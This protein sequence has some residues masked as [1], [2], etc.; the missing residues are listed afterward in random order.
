MQLKIEKHDDIIVEWI[1]YDHSIMLK[2]IGKDG[3]ATAIWK[4]GSLKYN[5]EVMKF[6]ILKMLLYFLLQQLLYYLTGLKH[7]S[8]KDGQGEIPKIYGIFHDPYTKEFF[9]VLDC[10][11]EICEVQLKIEEYKNIIVEW[12]PYDQ[13]NI[14]KEISFSKAYL[15][16][17]K[18]GSLKYNCEEINM[19]ENLI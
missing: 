17:W 16:I 2:K 15:A 1:P 6:E 8:I 12:I 13:F 9:I 11:C 14:I 3:F 19:K 4:D 18:N 7:Y 10:L 5:Y